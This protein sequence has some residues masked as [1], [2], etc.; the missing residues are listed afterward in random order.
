MTSELETNIVAVERIKEY[1]ELPV[2]GQ[3]S[4]RVPPENWPSQGDIR[5]NCASL[6]FVFQLSVTNVKMLI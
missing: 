6:R 2:E 1:A 4:H 3:K 5:I